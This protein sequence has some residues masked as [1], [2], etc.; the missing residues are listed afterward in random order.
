MVLLITLT[1]F[2]LGA[3]AFGDVLPSH[4]AAGDA[5]VR[6]TDGPCSA[7]DGYSRA[8]RAADE[9]DLIPDDLASLRRPRQG[10]FLILG[11]GHPILPIYL[12]ALR[13]LVYRYAYNRAFAA[14][15]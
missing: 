3:P 11:R 7:E 12:D 15:Y 5:A 8:V 14:S 6:V 10:Q 1:Q 13:V 2:L 4:H 9:P